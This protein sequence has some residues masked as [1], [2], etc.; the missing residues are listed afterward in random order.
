M[1]IIRHAPARTAHSRGFR[2][3]V[4]RIHRVAGPWLHE[5][6]ISWRLHSRLFT[7]L[8]LSG[9]C[10]WPATLLA[11]AFIAP[12]RNAFPARPSE[13]DVLSWYA[14]GALAGGAAVGVV[15]WLLLRTAFRL[16][17]PWVLVTAAGWGCA[18]TLAGWG[19][20]QFLAWLLV[21]LPWRRYLFGPP[22]WEIHALLG[23]AG[24]LLGLAIG[25]AQGVTLQRYLPAAWRWTLACVVA[26]PLGLQFV[27]RLPRM[28]SGWLLRDRFMGAM[29]A[30]LPA[31][32]LA[33]AV[34]GLLT[35]A[36]L[37]GMMRSAAPQPLET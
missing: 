25:A 36:A 9:A 32:V 15:Q 26:W 37:A 10:L 2:L 16:A 4:P 7:G 6:G 5:L 18:I 27:P 1:E 22:L 3:G 29:E 34:Y 17:W 8:I 35:A 31:L 28:P 30:D 19:V 12:A 24:M 23:L 33:G 14:G 20:T 13:G 21:V 11:L